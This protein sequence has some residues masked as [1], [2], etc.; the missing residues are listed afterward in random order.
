[1]QA[2]SQE[3]LVAFIGH[4]C[5][6]LDDEKFNDFLDACG[7]DF[8]YR[9]TTYSPDLG[10]EMVWLDHDRGEFEMMIKMLPEHV[11]TK[12][13]LSR[14]TTLVKAV[15]TD[16]GICQTKSKVAVYQT[17]LNGTST[18]LAI[19]H[20]LDSIDVSESEAPKLLNRELRLDTRDLGPGVCVPI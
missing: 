1:M 11:R 3:A 14:H 19:G 16:S 5:E 8:S 12:T 17:D 6:L 20:Y 4:T 13:K 2:T 7:A 15:K 18:I 9:V 10:K